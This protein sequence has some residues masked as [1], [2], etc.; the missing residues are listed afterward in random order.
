MS[1]PRGRQP[2][3][4]PRGRQGKVQG[5]VGTHEEGDKRRVHSNRESQQ[6]TLNKATVPRATNKEPQV[7]EA[8]PTIVGRRRQ[9]RVGPSG[10][11]PSS[12]DWHNIA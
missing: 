11:A 9:G 3:S 10:E 2:L 5:R 7:S 1:A 12:Q 6:E 8:R 4:A